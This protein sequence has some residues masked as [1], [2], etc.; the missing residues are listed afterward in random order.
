M[1]RSGLKLTL[2]PEGAATCREFAKSMRNT[3][4]NLEQAAKELKQS[5]NS[6]SGDLGVHEVNFVNVVDVVSGIL[7]EAYEPLTALSK[8]LDETASKIDNYVAKNPSINGN[9]SKK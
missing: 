4:Q 8:S 7:K 2:T 9:I 6:V 3:Y 5:C 1:N